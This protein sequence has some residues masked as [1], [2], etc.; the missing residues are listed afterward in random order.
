MPVCE[1]RRDRLARPVHRHAADGGMRPA[2]RTAPQCES[3]SPRVITTAPNFFCMPTDRRKAI[4]T[5]ERSANAPKALAEYKGLARPGC[6]CC[7][8]ENQRG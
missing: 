3:R 6:G 5:N 1:Y 7:S 4:A 2:A 8:T